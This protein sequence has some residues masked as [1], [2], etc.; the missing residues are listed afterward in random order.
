[1]AQDEE[2]MEVPTILPKA[3]YML[4]LVLGIGFYLIWSSLFDAWTDIAVYTVSVVLI[5]FGIIGT[6][7]YSTLEKESAED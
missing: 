2:I 4:L 7:L 1:M 3:F 6:I 5:G